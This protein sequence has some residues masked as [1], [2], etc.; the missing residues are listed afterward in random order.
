MLVIGWLV[1]DICKNIYFEKLDSVLANVIFHS[2]GKQ[3]LCKL[4]S[5][6]GMTLI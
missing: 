3:N 2:Q 5:V 1:Q 6:G 4:P